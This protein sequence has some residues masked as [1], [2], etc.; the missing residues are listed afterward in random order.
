MFR[1]K[2]FWLNYVELISAIAVLC[3]DGKFF[4][5]IKL[6]WKVLLLN[7]VEMNIFMAEF[8][9]DSSIMSDLR[10]LRWAS[11]WLRCDFLK[12]IVNYVCWDKRN[13]Y[14]FCVIWWELLLIC[15]EVRMLACWETCTRYQKIVLWWKCHGR[16]NKYHLVEGKQPDKMFTWVRG[17]YLILSSDKRTLQADSYIPCLLHQIFK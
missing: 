9:G 13:H 8:C 7:Y 6:T 10:V 1:W 17:K 2:V 5:V 3:W 11:S 15:I 16:G 12:S 4:W 14:G